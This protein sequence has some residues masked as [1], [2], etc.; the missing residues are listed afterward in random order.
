M[1]VPA[2]RTGGIC[3]SPDGQQLVYGGRKAVHV[4]DAGTG[5]ELRTI[6]EQT[7]DVHGVVCSSDGRTIAAI[8][9]GGQAVQVW[10]A[11]TGQLVHT[12]QGHGQGLHWLAVS[13][14]S[15]SLAAATD[16]RT[17]R[18]W[19]LPAGQLRH[20]LQGHTDWV[21]D[22]GFGPQSR[23]LV[24]C[25]YDRTV[26]LWDVI[27]G[28]PIRI[29]RG[30]GAWT[31]AAAFAPA[32]DQVI[33]GTVYGVLKFWDAR[34]DQE[35]WTYPYYGFVQSAGV[36]PD[37]TRLAIVNGSGLL[38]LVDAH[39]ARTVCQV[40][41]DRVRMVQYSPDGRWLFLRREGQPLERRDAANGQL[42]HTYEGDPSG[43]VAFALD[44]SGQRI[45]SIDGDQVL[46]ARDVLTGR[47]LIPQEKLPN[48]FRAGPLCFSGDGRWLFLGNAHGDVQVRDAATA[49]LRRTI[50]GHR[51]AISC[52]AASA[53]GCY[54]A[55]G[56]V[57]RTVKLWDVP[58]GHE[59][60][61]LR[62]HS[63]RV[64]AVTFTPDGKR[65]VSGCYERAIKMWGTANGQELLPLPGHRGSVT[66]LTFSA[67]GRWLLSSSED[68]SV[69]LWDAGEHWSLPGVP[70]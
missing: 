40:P 35:C 8:V 25:S 4:V 45:A 60:A 15:R 44:A 3:F 58:T 13:P 17:I 66:S 68:G 38:L 65:L 62:G 31:T 20:V 54:L 32:G 12:L 64:T 29:L 37:G 26:R 50:S 63:G 36:S 19:D 14:D 5:K 52:L 30:N 59:R 48:E 28:H 42:L 27:T 57:D 49:Q 11:T 1:A 46:K 70:R 33:T 67:D 51:K 16:A 56:S 34:R 61:T 10:D 22:I 24:S 69:R 23:W 21:T 43:V 39:S 9:H 53:D 47:L 18:V 7:G 55:S 2:E 6:G 41:L